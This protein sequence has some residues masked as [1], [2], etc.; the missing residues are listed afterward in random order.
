MKFYI[1]YNPLAGS[2]S[3]TKKAQILAQQNNAECT[4]IDMTLADNYDS[5]VEKAANNDK[6]IICGGDGTLNH[7]INK[8][9][10]D[11]LNRDIYYYPAGTGNDF[12]N[13]VGGA[14][15]DGL[16][17][18][19]DYIK[20]LPSVHTENG[21]QFFTNGIGYGVDG[22]CCEEVNRL[23]SL[24]RKNVSYPLIA[25]KGL[26]FAYKPTNAVVTV[27]GQSFK[28]EKVWLASTM[29]GKFFGGGIK[30]APMQDRKNKSGKLS[31][32]IAHSLGTL[33]ILRLFPSIF[34]GTH[35]KYK[36]FV[37]VHEGYDITVE[38]DRSCAMQIDG[39]TKSM[40]SS[41]RVVKENS[42]SYV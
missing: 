42:H 41:Y 26:L 23:K 1:L 39:E 25:L 21:K 13:D 7:F 9:T 30:I 35:I 8:V 18:I 20:N 12:F 19:N 34:K 24:K 27:D 22:Y 37:A 38:F 14:D 3:C 31:L 33:N 17:K 29:L 2:G 16:I 10:I 36:K 5:I 40:I 4:I 15:K 6:I 32:V 28:Y 11:N